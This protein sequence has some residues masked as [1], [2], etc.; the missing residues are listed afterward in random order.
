MA[1]GIFVSGS[2]FRVLEIGP[3]VGRVFADRDDMRGCPATAVIS[4]AF[5]RS[6][7]GAESSA[8][9]RKLLL[10]GKSF[11]IIGV[12]AAGFSG[13]NVGKRFD[14]AVPLC[15]EPLL[16]RGKRSRRPC[17]LVAEHHGA[18]E[19]LVFPF[20]RRARILPP[21]GL[22]SSARRLIQPGF[23]TFVKDYLRLRVRAEPGRTGFSTLRY[24]VEQL[25]LLLLC[26]CRT[27]AA[28]RLH[29]SCEPVASS[30]R[31]ARS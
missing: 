4:D 6:E 15:S 14:V 27:C 5:W 10:E 20:S 21:F 13:L 9:G 19:D 8:V 29:Q 2:F 25:L 31:H 12:S 26:D 23:P 22:A 7:F 18:I 28:H 16:A 11:Q 17:H 3:E 30:G 1:N 24:E